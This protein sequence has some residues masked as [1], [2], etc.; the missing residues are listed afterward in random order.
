M[1]RARDARAPPA[2][3]TVVSVIIQRVEGMVVTVHWV[4]PGVGVPVHC[5]RRR[6]GS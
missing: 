4:G 3:A 2:A 5:C 6:H 1:P